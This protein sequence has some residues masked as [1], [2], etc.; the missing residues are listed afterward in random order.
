MYGV[1]IAFKDFSITK[2]IIGSPWVGGENFKYLFESKQFFT[3]FKNSIVFSM[4]R[5]AAGFPAPIILALLLNEVK[6]MRFK[7]T[8]QTVSYIPHFISWVVVCG[9]VKNIFSPTAEGIVNAAIKA[10]GGQP[11]QF[12]ISTFWFRPII[13]ISEIWKE[14]GWGA[15]IYLAA[16]SGIDPTLYEAA[17]VDG[18]SRWQR[19]VH[20]TLPGII[21]TIIVLLILRMGRIL[22]NGFEQ[23]FLLY[24]PMVYEVAD[25]F[26]TYTYRTGLIERRFSY[27]TAVGLFKAVV[28]LIMVYSTN[29]LARKT[30]EKALW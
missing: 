14:V 4:L 18:A 9:M 13:I 22:N 8:V 3:V 19:M 24:S 23:I 10:L 6:H 15:I 17:I 30:G 1:I 27:S 25:V 7:R 29:Y 11:I 21:S 2:G 16:L 28:G 26:E 5:L 12:L 20:V